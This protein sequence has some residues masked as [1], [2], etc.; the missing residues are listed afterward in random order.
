MGYSY[1]FTF[2]KKNIMSNTIKRA[3]ALKEMETRETTAGKPNYFSIQFYK[4]DG[5]LVSLNRAK[6]TGLRANMSANRLRG[7][8]AVDAEGNPI[9]H[10]YPVSIDNIRTLN[11]Q[12]VVI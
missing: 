5:E 12:Q 8:Q 7:I 2:A 4:K 6:V 3:D 1:L 9:G 10:I 11:S